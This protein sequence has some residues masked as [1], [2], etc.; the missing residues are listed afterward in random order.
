MERLDGQVALVT[1]GAS[2][3]GRAIVERFI[4]EGARVGVLD[5][6]EER[7]AQLSE[8]FGDRVVCVRGDVRSLPDNDNAV[9]QCFFAAIGADKRQANVFQMS[10]D[11]IQWLATEG[12]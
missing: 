11:G 3:L 2:G 1:G 7:L 8:K 5:L 12:L 9:A 10:A 4:S 6:S